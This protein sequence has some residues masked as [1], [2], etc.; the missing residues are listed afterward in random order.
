MQ[1]NGDGMQCRVVQEPM[2][3][4]DTRRLRYDGSIVR[5]KAQR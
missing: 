5:H 3:C 4:F 2:E 1:S